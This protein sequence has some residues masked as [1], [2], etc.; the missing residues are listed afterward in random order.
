MTWLDTHKALFSLFLLLLGNALSILNGLIP[1]VPA[2][3]QGV[4]VKVVAVLRWILDLPM[5]TTAK[6]SPHTIKLPFTWS[7]PP[8]K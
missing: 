4:L 7:K 2:K 3:P 1:Y 6:D 5:P 8:A